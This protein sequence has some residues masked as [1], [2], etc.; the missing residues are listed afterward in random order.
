MPLGA[1]GAFATI[2]GMSQWVQEEQF[3]A[4]PRLTRAVTIILIVTVA[5]FVVQLLAVNVFRW[6]GVEDIF[7]LSEAG[8]VHGRI[9]QFVTYI[10]LHSRVNLLHILFNMLGLCFMGPEVE[11]A[12]GTRRFLL[13]Y[14]VCGILG[15]AGWLL[16]SFKAGGLCI[17]A[18]GA[19][20]GIL[21]AFA[22]LYP[23]RSITLLLFFVLPVTMKARVLAIVF[24]LVSL[25]MMFVYEAGGVA[26]SAHLAGGLAGYLYAARL[27]RTQAFG[28]YD[29]Y[30]DDD[31]SGWR[32]WLRGLGARMRAARRGRLEPDPVEVDRILEKVA[33]SGLNSLTRRERDTL[34]RASRMR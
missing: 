19:V 3:I 13:L 8:V 17:G 2:P 26:H 11:R 9:W 12:L 31:N 18:S 1:R 10:F 24:G 32:G 20:F 34:D 33:E 4:L 25:V 14:L 16:L 23:H 30:A 27:A 5:A 6:S 7:G 21:G 15:G 22:A 29:R 28:L